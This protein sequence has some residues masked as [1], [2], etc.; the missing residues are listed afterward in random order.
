MMELTLFIIA[1]V[2]FGWVLWSIIRLN[3]QGATIEVLRRDTLRLSKRLGGY[4]S[5]ADKR[6]RK[7]IC[8]ARLNAFAEAMVGVERPTTAT[9]DGISKEIAKLQDKAQRDLDVLTDGDNG[10]A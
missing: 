4:Q 5:R 2:E 9:R 10:P 6:R 7:A 8:Q 1:I 3:S